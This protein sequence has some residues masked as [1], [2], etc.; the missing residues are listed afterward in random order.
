MITLSKA[1]RDLFSGLILM[2]IAASL[3]SITMT[4]PTLNDGYPGP[5]LFPQIIAILLGL[6]GLYLCLASILSKQTAH[7]SSELDQQKGRLTLFFGGIL[8]VVIFPLLI[9]HVHFIVIMGGF[10]LFFGLILQNPLWKAILTALLSAV[11]IYAM[12]TQLLG[13]PL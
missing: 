5:A 6:L 11:L 10:I 9:D 2:A 8:L 7:P 12:F 1:K 4:F 13:V 3:W